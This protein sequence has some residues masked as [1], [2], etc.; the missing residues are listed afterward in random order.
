MARATAAPAV[1]LNVPVLVAGLVTP[2]SATKGPVLSWLVGTVAVAEV[3]PAVPVLAEELAVAAVDVDVL[4]ADTVMVINNAVDVA[5]TVKE[6][7]SSAP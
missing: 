2:V 5:V 1:E 3:T 6:A 7:H 4:A